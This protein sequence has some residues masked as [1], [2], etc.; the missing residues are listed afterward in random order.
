[1]IILDTNVLSELLKPAPAVEVLGW[2]ALRLLPG[3]FTTTIS[4]AEMLFGI[5]IMPK[6]KRRSALL[7]RRCSK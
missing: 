2:L 1:M 5:E 6:G 7:L 4:R 3:M